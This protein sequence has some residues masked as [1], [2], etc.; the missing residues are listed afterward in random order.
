MYEDAPTIHVKSARSGR[1]GVSA[2]RYIW[3]HICSIINVLILL[4]IYVNIWVPH[5]DTHTNTRPKPTLGSMTR[6]EKRLKGP[7]PSPLCDSLLFTNNKYM[8]K[9]KHRTHQHTHAHTHTHTHTELQI[10][11]NY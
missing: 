4:S 1:C 8:E 2:Y 6:F 7:R 5:T 3:I 10:I 9:M 11:N